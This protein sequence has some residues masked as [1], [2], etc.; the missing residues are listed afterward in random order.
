MVKHTLDAAALLEQEGIQAEVVNMRFVKP[1]DIE[2]LESIARR[3]DA[4]VTVEDNVIQGGF[5]SAVLEALQ[6]VGATHV[7][8]KLH[9]LPDKFIDQGSPSELYKICRIDA[10]GIAEI[11]Q[12]FLT[13]KH[14]KSTFEFIGS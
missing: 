7:A 14:G 13:S 4:I 9:G 3:F 8:V 12:E 5:G 6:T 11:T 10:K 1:L 2:M